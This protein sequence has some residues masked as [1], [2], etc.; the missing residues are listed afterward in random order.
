[1]MHIGLGPIAKI[2]NI[3]DYMTNA[4]V[5]DKR[6]LQQRLYDFLD[7]SFNV[8]VSKLD[9]YIRDNSFIETE[10]E[11]TFMADFIID[12]DELK[13]SYQVS[14]V[15][16]NDKATSENPIFDC[17][18]L[19]NV[20][21]PE[22]EC[23]GMYNSTQLL[24]AEQSNPVYS[25]LPIIVDEFD[26]ES[27]VTTRYDIRGFFDY[28]DN[29]FSINITDYSCGN[30]ENALQSIRDRGFNPE[31]YKINYQNECIFD[32]LPYIGNNSLGDRFSIDY[33]FT[34]ENKIYFLINN[35][36]CAD[37]AASEKAA[38]EAT[39]D[40]LLL[41]NFNIENYQYGVLTLCE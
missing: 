2:R 8:D 36:G 22:T 28:D 39:S 25:V 10:S 37:E 19:D 34:E 29:E 41:H 15:F 26:A 4:T 16:P 14:Y 27:G 18:S 1:M 35:Y 6:L 33:T 13:I 5:D 24:E 40:W 30:Y 23:V 32:D 21:Y 3:D 9:I 20:K 12:I 17:P 38:I 31:D 7:S 11:G